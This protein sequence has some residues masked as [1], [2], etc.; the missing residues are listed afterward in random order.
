MGFRSM[1]LNV[2]IG[3]VFGQLTV[4]KIEGRGAGKARAA[5]CV[6]S[7]GR[8]YLADA[9]QLMRGVTWRCRTCANPKIYTHAEYLRRQSYFNY[10]NGAKRRGYDYLLTMDEFL[11]FTDSPCTYCG[12]APAKGV[13]RR[14]NSI[15]Y[16][17][18]NCV[19]CC[20]QCNLAKRDMTE[21][22][23]FLWLQR[24]AAHQESWI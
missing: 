17:L 19:P 3:H 23:F 4:Q 7:C 10:K 1:T 16:I 11:K 2:Q 15:G 22:E 12:L 9:G 13:D 20:K 24:L 8:P 14:N 21:K 5:Y 18:E 6:C